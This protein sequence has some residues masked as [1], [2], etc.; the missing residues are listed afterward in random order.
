MFVGTV[1]IEKDAISSFE[2]NQNRVAT[3]FIFVS[4]RDCTS[5]LF[6]QR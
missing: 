6:Q 1:T 3:L 5:S 4:T 2:T